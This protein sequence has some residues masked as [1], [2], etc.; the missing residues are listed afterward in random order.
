MSRYIATIEFDTD[1]NEDDGVVV[2][3]KSTLN[4][5][6]P[7]MVD[8]V[9]V[10]IKKDVNSD[11]NLLVEAYIRA[12]ELADGGSETAKGEVKQCIEAVY[13]LGFNKTWLDLAA[14]IT[15]RNEK[16]EKKENDNA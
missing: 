6:L 16:F 7:Y 1:D 3:L 9:T 2:V 13:E 14:S 15:A 8:N 12:V 5:I 10:N 4:N 11:L